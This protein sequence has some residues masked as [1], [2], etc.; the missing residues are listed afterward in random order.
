MKPEGIAIHNTANDASAMSEISYMQGNN[1][2]VSFHFA[3]D[4][5][6]AV[7]GIE[8]NRNAWHAGDGRNGRG[9]RKMIAIEICYSKSGGVRFQKAQENAAILVAEL[10]EEYGWG[11]EA[12]HTHKDFNG[13]NCPHRTLGDYGF[14]YFLN[15]VKKHLDDADVKEAVG[16]PKKTNEELAEEV[17]AGKW[18]NGNERRQ[19][20]TA[21]GYD[22]NA[23]Q[24]IVN[25][26]KPIVSKKSN[27]EIATEVLAGKWGNGAERKQRLAAAGYDYNAIQA[28]VNNKSK[29]AKKSNADIAKEVLA[30]KW[31]NGAERKQRLAAAGYD[32]AAIQAIVNKS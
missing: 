10:L 2:S 32:Y 4:D 18:G 16:K 14:G 1:K 5:Y 27:E 28:I 3:V 6:R 9:N 22:Y 31:G 12:I 23:V 21:A 29:S 8:L 7:Q 26:K 20:L 24:A 15:L 17:L 30:G 11:I 19:R 13:K 25:K